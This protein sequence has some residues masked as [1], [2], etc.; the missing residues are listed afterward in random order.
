MK[1]HFEHRKLCNVSSIKLR[2]VIAS[3]LGEKKKKKEREEGEEEE[4]DNKGLQS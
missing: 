3:L 4:D 2:P 1:L